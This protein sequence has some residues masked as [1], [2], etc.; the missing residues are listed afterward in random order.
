MLTEHMKTCTIHKNDCSASVRTVPARFSIIV[1]PMRSRGSSFIAVFF[2]YSIMGFRST[3]YNGFI[4]PCFKHQHGL[5]QKR[6][7]KKRHIHVS[8]SNYFRARI[9]YFRGTR[10]LPLQLKS[11][12]AFR[13]ISPLLN[14]NHGCSKNMRVRI[15]YSLRNKRYNASN[16]MQ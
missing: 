10:P 15:P 9:V 6:S 5:F 2:L 11:T 14:K 13:L 1:H 12:V 8:A 3:I 16:H 4:Y 7:G